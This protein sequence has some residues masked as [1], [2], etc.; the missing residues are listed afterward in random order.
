[1]PAI[2]L[3]LLSI[4]TWQ[5]T[6]IYQSSAQ[7][8]LDV[9]KKNPDSWL[10]HNN[11]GLLLLAAN[12]DPQAWHEF[13]TALAL[14]PQLTQA[15]INFGIIAERRGDFAA[16]MRYYQ[17]AAEQWD[18]KPWLGAGRAEP[19]VHLGALFTRTGKTQDAIDAYQAALVRHPRHTI[20]MNNLGMLYAARAQYDR[21]IDLFVQVLAIDPDSIGTRRN[22]AD[23]YF[24]SGRMS[25]AIEQ[26]NKILE[27]DPNSA[28]AAN[29]LGLIFA[30]MGHWDEAIAMFKAALERDPNHIA[31]RKNLT[32]AMH[33]RSAR[34]NKRSTS[35]PTRN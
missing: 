16:A 25:E 1:M 7:I 9:L 3:T 2:V 31:A 14:N 33:E 23:A 17:D 8:W 21:A 4:L 6:H 27:H 32:D 35:V 12:R 22:L 24:R 28:D 30:N 5:Q 19:Y 20:A 29:G 13:E 10:A 18:K 34:M 15:V 26:W 11:Y